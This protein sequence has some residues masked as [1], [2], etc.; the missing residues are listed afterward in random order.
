[1]IGGVVGRW[2][3]ESGGRDGLEGGLESAGL[4]LRHVKQGRS[5]RGP[6]MEREEDE[7]EVVP[8]Q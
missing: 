2:Q 3:T 4:R 5:A 1:V 8:G 6:R 7:G